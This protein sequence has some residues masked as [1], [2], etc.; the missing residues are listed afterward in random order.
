MPKTTI[1]LHVI[2]ISFSWVFFVYG[3][4]LHAQ[5]VEYS[6]GDFE[7]K[8][9]MSQAMD[10][11][12]AYISGLREPYQG[13]D[14]S[15][16]E[17]GVLP[18]IAN[19]NVNNR[20]YTGT[21]DSDTASA[22][23]WKRLAFQMEVSSFDN[24]NVPSQENI[25][26]NA[27]TARQD[28]TIPIGLILMEVDRFTDKA[29]DPSEDLL[30]ID[31]EDNTMSIIDPSQADSIFET[32]MVV[33]AAALRGSIRPPY[34]GSFSIQ[35]QNNML[36]IPSWKRFAIDTIEINLNSHISDEWQ[37]IGFDKFQVPGHY[38]T[39]KIHPTLRITVGDDVHYANF[40]IE[41]FGSSNFTIPDERYDCQDTGGW[42]CPDFVKGYDINIHSEGIPPRS[43]L[44][45]GTP[46]DILDQYDGD[47]SRGYMYG[48]YYSFGSDS[49]TNPIII[50]NGIDPFYNRTVDVIYNGLIESDFNGFGTHLREQGYDIVIMDYYDSLDLVQRNALALVD[51]IE[52]INGDHPSSP[53]SHGIL[54]GEA[55]IHAIIGP[56]LGS[57]IGRWALLY[58]ENNNMQHN[59]DNYVSYDGIHQGANIP[60]GFQR[61]IVDILENN[62]ITGLAASFFDAIGELRDLLHTPSLRQSLLYNDFN[63]SGAHDPLRMDLVSEFFDMGDY[64][65][66]TKNNVAVANGSRLDKPQKRFSDGSAALLTPSDVLTDVGVG[67]FTLVVGGKFELRS[68]A[69][70]EGQPVHRRRDGACFDVGIFT[71]CLWHT[72]HYTPPYTY[73]T[74]DHTAG[75]FRDSFDDL[76]AVPDSLQGTSLLTSLVNHYG[77]E[78]L[79][80][81]IGAG[82]EL[83]RLLEPTIYALAV[84]ARLDI[85]LDVQAS[86]HNF[87]PTLSA[88]DAN[89]SGVTRGQL[90]NSGYAGQDYTAV[91]G[92]NPDTEFDG[93][94]MAGDYEDPLDN[95][96]H[97][98]FTYGI[99]TFLL[100]ELNVPEEGLPPSPP[101]DLVVTGNDGGMPTIEWEPSNHGLVDDYHLYRSTFGCITCWELI[102]SGPGTSWTD[103][104]VTINEGDPETAFYYRVNAESPSGAISDYSNTAQITG[105]EGPPWMNNLASDEGAVEIPDEF[106]VT[107]VYPN[108]FTHFVSLDVD[109]PEAATIDVAIFNSAGQQ[110]YES[111]QALRPGYHTIQWQPR[112]LASG[113][114]HA[115]IHTPKGPFTQSMVY[116]NR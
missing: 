2:A 45:Y 54:D 21:L 87:V 39:G 37:E 47:Q 60:I 79:R 64:P 43:E 86:R 24:V 84:S 65:A 93:V 5:D 15:L 26:S 31:E 66:E 13:L 80:A 76:K 11:T 48:V 115:R 85:E 110:V 14:L 83:I 70:E 35:V 38:I 25:H 94:Y 98:E 102:A 100:D 1:W 97:V 19:L 57:L 9:L 7:Y 90:L 96:A 8:T 20:A 91:S 116:V 6:V 53:A 49:L 78:D 92:A 10:D 72:S 71:R 30:D 67:V 32:G 36:T 95:Q 82:H 108:P 34:Y 42:E 16:T 104:Q 77:S 106:D 17:T 112:N 114:Y 107:S 113:V 61:S 12:P 50:L 27:A 44:I 105:D 41:I 28:G 111:S 18:D 56:S 63:Q 33:S 4:T 109:V 22:T 81:G 46:I 74:I 103:S 59:V 51:L 99:R 29:L 3:S 68:F 89:N 62:V 55:P 73:Q 101:F 52:R 23:D 88:V 75:G 40:E 69:A 58:M